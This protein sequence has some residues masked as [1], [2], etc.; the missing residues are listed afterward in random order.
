MP[1]A[2]LDLPN[3]SHVKAFRTLERI[4][5]NDPTL[6][7]VLRQLWSWDGSDKDDLDP[8][9]DTCPS[10]AIACAMGDD[11]WRGPANFE[12]PLLVRFAWAVAGTRSD[13]LINLIHATKRAIY[14][15]SPAA[16]EP[17]RAALVAAGATT[18][19]G[20]FSRIDAGTMEDESGGAM[21]AGSATFT[22]D[23]DQL[24]NP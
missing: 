23:I 5:R 14:P 11:Q 2:A 17:N 6:K 12:G 9:V 1:T 3:C 16:R 22:L 20:V 13:N 8:T 15:A 7:R 19:E 18:G 24:L 21:L 4:L 10:L